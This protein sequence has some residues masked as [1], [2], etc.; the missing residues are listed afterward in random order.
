MHSRR[1][2]IRQTSKWLTN[3]YE[4]KFI[5]KSINLYSYMSVVL[6]SQRS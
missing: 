5:Y 2:E 6:E 3:L 4:Y 1:L